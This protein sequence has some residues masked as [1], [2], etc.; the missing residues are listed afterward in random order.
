MLSAREA[1]RRLYGYLPPGIVKR[2]GPDRRKM[3]E[4][5]SEALQSNV[6]QRIDWLRVETNP[7]QIVRF[8]PSWQA[9]LD[10]AST[11]IAT[12]GNV[13]Q[14]QA[15]VVAGIRACSGNLSIPSL[16]ALLGPFLDYAD[17]AQLVVLEP[18]RA[19]LRTAH[20]YS[21]TTTLPA[22][23]PNV[24]PPLVCEWTIA[25]DGPVSEAGAQVV[26]NI[27]G[28]LEDLTFTLYG[29][30][31]VNQQVFFDR[32]ELGEGAVVAKSFMLYASS[33]KVR[34]DAQS[35]K[36]PTRG[37]WRLICASQ[38]AAGTLHD[39]SLFVEAHGRAASGV[40]GLGKSLFEIAV[41]ADPLLM[42]PNA[43]IE[44]ASDGLLRNKPAW[45]GASIVKKTAMGGVSAI[46]DL[47]ETLPDVS[48]PA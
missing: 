38:G 9:A 4:A 1:I 22:A 23:I 13:K 2:L 3:L 19:A 25:D 34:L 15:Q 32:G 30:G 12:T 42:G 39:A 45:L 24:F 40:E 46:P 21:P 33:N 41:I 14:Q 47:P 29:P 16:Q 6:E 5:L 20:T 44:A 37:V 28:N 11:R 27:T 36:G 31:G 18:D 48:I 7:A 17:P 10:L 26:V 35:I 8:L 43:D